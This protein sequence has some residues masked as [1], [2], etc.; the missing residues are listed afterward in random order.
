MPLFGSTLPQSRID[1][2]ASESITVATRL[3]TEPASATVSRVIDDVSNPER[4]PFLD[5]SSRSR[6]NQRLNVDGAPACSQAQ[7]TSSPCTI[8]PLPYASPPITLIVAGLSSRSSHAIFYVHADLLISVSSFFRAAFDNHNSKAGF[9]EASTLT[10]R[11]PEQRVDDMAYLVQWLYAPKGVPT[12]QT[13]H[14]DLIDLPLQQMEKYKQERAI[15]QLAEKHG[16]ISQLVSPRP[17]P[18]AFGPLVRLYI[19]ADRLS[20]D[21]GLSSAICTRMDGNDD[22]FDWHPLFMRALVIRL[23]RDKRE[24]RKA[25]CIKTTKCKCGH[26]KTAGESKDSTGET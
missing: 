14:H 11:L 1:P 2:S 6:I 13:L 24:V 16:D 7:D 20:V 23:L 25:P 4:L 22:D 8:S 19:L 10:M 5:T 21:G 3:P 26:D 9:L 15:V 12:V 17:A 18:P